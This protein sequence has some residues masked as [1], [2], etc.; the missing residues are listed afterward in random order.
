MLLRVKTETSVYLVVFI[1]Y[2]NTRFDIKV[3]LA[4]KRGMWHF[5]L[6]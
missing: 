6:T 2:D 5:T 1:M 4:L 3:K